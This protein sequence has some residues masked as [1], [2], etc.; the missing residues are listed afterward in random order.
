MIMLL[1]TVDGVCCCFWLRRCSVISFVLCSFDTFVLPLMRPS[2]SFSLMHEYTCRAKTLGV[3]I[4]DFYYELS[5]K[6][7]EVCFATRTK[8]GG[9]MSVTDVCDTLN[10]TSN[11]NN[12]IGSS[13]RVSSTTLGRKK[14]PSK[15]K[16]T[17]TTYSRGDVTIA[18]QKLST[19]GGG[20]RIV[21]VGT[22]C[23]MIV[24][25]PTELDH[26]HMEIMTLAAADRHR[27]EGQHQHTPE[28]VRTIGCITVEDVYQHL[29][30]TTERTDR[31]ITLLLNEGMAWKDEYHGIAFYWFPSIWNNTMAL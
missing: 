28:K 2:S 9:I 25:V 6:V 18:V 14:R 1:Q 22:N 3:G 7:A 10:N 21:T 15:L 4:G 23:E 16:S 30:W 11:N 31:A 5:V 17:N 26:D 13:S 29:K 12:K 24:S 27:E 8:N 19:L 20:F